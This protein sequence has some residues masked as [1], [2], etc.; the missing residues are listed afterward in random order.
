MNKQPDDIKRPAPA[1]DRKTRDLTALS[2][3]ILPLTK[4]L[5]GKKGF[6]EVDILTNWDKIVGAELADYSFP[7]KIDFKREQKNNG[8][9]HL[10]VPSGAFALEIQHREKYIIEKIN[11]Y[12]GY[13][14]VC[15]L[16][17][18]QN[19]SLSPRDENKYISDTPQK[20]LVSE[21]EQNYIKS[22]ANDIKDSKLKEILIKLG[23]SIFND[24]HKEK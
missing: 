23:Q 1:S 14:A 4:N 17:I 16:K 19:N 2:R 13:N 20:N 8:I 7:Q 12:F 15:G 11:A 10:Q 3:A 6:V 9:L 5:F 22:L 18:L 24:N 21:E